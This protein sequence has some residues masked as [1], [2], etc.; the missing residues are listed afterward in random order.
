[1]SD[2]RTGAGPGMTGPRDSG[3]LFSKELSIPGGP[4]ERAFLG[5]R[6]AALRTSGAQA[7]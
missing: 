7:E 3:R 5:G 6:L 4:S 1:M 2:E